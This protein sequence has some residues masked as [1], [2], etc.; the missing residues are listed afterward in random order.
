M[1]A[2][3]VHRLDAGLG[4]LVVD[5]IPKPVPQPGEV[6]VRVH[7][8]PVNPADVLAV[9]GRYVV[10]REVP[11]TPGVVGVGTV[12]Q[13][14]AGL[15]GRALVGRR[16]VFAVPPEQDGSWAEAVR[17]PAALC[18]PLSRGIGDEEAVNLL[19]NGATAVGLVRELRRESHRSV[20]VTG[21]AGE[22]GRMLVAHGE[23]HGVAVLPVVRTEAHA[24]SLGGPTD[25]VVVT[26]QPDVE[27]ALAGAF[28][29]HAVT[30]V[31]DAVGG[32][33]LGSL[34]RAL[35][36]RGTIWVLGRLSGRDATFDAFEHMVGREQVLRGFNVG[37]WLERQA[38]PVQ[39]R[40]VAQARALTS[41]KHGTRVAHRLSLEDAARELAEAVTTTTAGKT[42]LRPAA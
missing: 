12:E 25:Q 22:L 14:K 18:V 7:C 10:R 40:T 17:T 30:A 8:A 3:R 1:R 9:Q 33:L 16:V 13:A 11:F 32:P 21:A 28:G 37:A 41:G 31:V 6:L 4:G 39:L 5:E 35:P 24:R 15:L 27:A 29:A 34:L 19:A 36:A 23:R 42:I 2:L 26:E 38:K 20:A